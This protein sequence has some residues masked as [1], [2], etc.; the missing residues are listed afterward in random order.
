[1]TIFGTIGIFVKYTPIPSSVIAMI[2]GFSGMLFLL[3]VMAICRFNISF[4]T[5][6]KKALPLFISGAF[7]GINWILLFESYRYTTVATATLCYYMA[8]VLV[9]LLSPII[10]KERLTLKK[11]ACVAVALAGIVL[12][13]GI[14]QSGGFYVS[15]IRGVLL[16][17][18]AALLY[19]TVVLMNKLLSDVPT[20]ERTAIQ[21]GSAAI[22]ILPYTL[23]T[24][25]F[26]KLE[27]TPQTVIL[28]L[29]MGVVH[30]G[31][32]YALYFD[33]IGKLPTQTAA[34]FS[35]IDP[36]VAIALSAVLLNEPMELPAIIGAI[37]ILGATF[38]S[39]LPKK[40]I[41]L[42]QQNCGRLLFY[43]SISRLY[44]CSQSL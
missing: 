24:E 33:S 38:I 9:I 5:I 17:L 41:S 12:V 1:M 7:I 36:I 20:Y 35:Y 16:G 8:P 44:R 2:R 40:K 42:P 13:S 34:I 43:I 11:L 31:V 18:G 21:L 29:V 3:A 4:N 26:A 27:F 30:T 6:R 23:L 39:E 10:L 25:N 19:A 22:V 37:L 14:L 32:A 28:L 15:E